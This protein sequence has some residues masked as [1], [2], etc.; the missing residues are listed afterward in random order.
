MNGRWV[1]VS[2]SIWLL[3]PLNSN[4]QK[5][6][7]GVIRDGTTGAALPAATIQVKDTF[8]GT[9]ANDNGDFILYLK[10]TPATIQITN[11]GYKSQEQAI[12]TTSDDVI[13][14]EL[15]PVPYQMEETVVLAED[16][17]VRIMREVIRRKR[18]WHPTIDNYRAEA[19]TYQSVANDTR[20]ATIRQAILEVFWDREKG[21][22]QV[23]KSEYSTANSAHFEK[24]ISLWIAP[25]F[26]QDE[27]ELQGHQVIGPT[28]PDAL[29]Y[30]AF[31]LV[32]KRLLD[33][34]IV[35]D[36]AIAPR[37]ELQA[38]FAGSLA[39]LDGDYALL[40]ANLR[41][42]KSIE[43]APQPFI[44]GLAF[45][46]KQQFRRFGRGVWLP[47]D[48][49]YEI[50]GKL[51]ISGLHFPVMTIK[52][53][54]R[55][56]AYQF[57]TSLSD[58]IF[59]NAERL[60][61]DTLSVRRDSLFTRYPDKVPLTAEQA[62]AYDALDSNYTLVKA[63]PP[64]GVFARFIED[65]WIPEP[66]KS[67]QEERDG[68]KPEVWYN[69]VDSA[70][71]GIVAEKHFAPLLKT[72]VMG[73]YNSGLVRWFYGGGIRYL[74]GKDS[75][76]H[77]TIDYQEGTAARYNSDSYEPVINSLHILLGKND[78]FDYFWNKSLHAGVGYYMK[79]LNTKVGMEIGNEVH[80]S[81]EKSTDFALLEGS[82]KQRVNPRIAEGTL[83]SI[84][85]TANYGGEYTGWGVFIH[86]RAELKIE[87]SS[88][89][90]LASDF[91]F[92]HYRLIIDW[93]FPTFF[94][95]RFGPNALDLRL[96]AGASAGELPVQ[97]FG[98][99]EASYNG[100]TPFGT[101]RTLNGNP[102]EGERYAGL[103]WEHNFKSV[104]FE[105]LGM[106]DMGKKGMGIVLHGASG[107][108]W[109]GKRKIPSLGYA[110]NYVE[111]YHHEIGLSLQIS[112]VLR[113]DFTRRLDRSGWSVGLSPAR[114]DFMSQDVVEK[115]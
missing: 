5:T 34:K 108:T 8:T 93:H 66:P 61:R 71:L 95:R 43:S 56:S 100:F 10:T 11:I 26:Y 4:A 109:I 55:F 78:Y 21:V 41:A 2:I 99:L 57:N 47:V 72:Q 13:H 63:F 59:E 19:Y 45:S 23:L 107:R 111:K 103:F 25:D 83:R 84:A 81:V 48:L 90:W 92:T 22:R 29:D 105:L 102:Y 16:P 33:D 110:P 40:E 14:I 85:L 28:H 39:V 114:L 17:A 82:E 1:L 88:R 86:K 3:N 91:S 101:F 89:N 27:I 53:V 15:E 36:I 60:Q 79:A 20:I 31:E 52:G 98:A 62:A 38:A 94:R 7:R 77:L 87:H 50:K 73:G 9:I 80:T 18:E 76:G 54:S 51:G 12:S 115:R 113:L 67:P 96:V 46:F 74:W 106:W 24:T 68:F 65:D 112:G 70:H 64:S 32:G 42:S 75:N 44:E 37:S 104:P 30:Y 58:S 35:Y 49:R 69:R 97:R 6:I